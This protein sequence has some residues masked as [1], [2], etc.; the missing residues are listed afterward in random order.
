LIAAAGAACVTFAASD[1][2]G[3]GGLLYPLWLSIELRLDVGLLLPPLRLAKSKSMS[4]MPKSSPL[5]LPNKSSDAVLL[6]EAEAAALAPGRFLDEGE[7]CSGAAADAAAGLDA[8]GAA[9]AA[10]F[11]GAATTADAV[12]FLAL[13]FFGD[14]GLSSSLSPSELSLLKSKSTL[15]PSSTSDSS[16]EKT[17]LAL[18]AAAAEGG[19][20]LVGGAGLLAA[21]ATATGCDGGGSR[22]VFGW[23]LAA[24]GTDGA[25]AAA[26]AGARGG[27]G[28]GG[29]ASPSG[30]S[31][32][33]SP[34]LASLPVSDRPRSKERLMAEG[35]AR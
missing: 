11:A 1:G 16:S 22:G 21:A 4:S 29:G 18:A 31:A 3:G 9:A 32:S 14:G 27:G 15:P 17:V 23:C 12:A 8:A 10:G 24:A 30:R 6:T 35:D 19:A 2:G 25:V 28:G 7:V 26:A 34:K 33:K 5:A 20:G 13:S